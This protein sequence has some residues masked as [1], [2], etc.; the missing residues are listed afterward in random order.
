MLDIKVSIENKEVVIQGLDKLGFGIDIA[1]TKGLQ[2]A[3]V[4][5]FGIAFQW[6]SGAGGQT[7]TYSREWS[8][9]GEIRR[10][11]K[12]GAAPGG[13]P[14]PVRTGNLRRLLNWLW[15]G[16]SKSG[17]AG[18]FTAGPDEFVIYDSASYAAA[19]F[20]GRGSSAPYGPR[21]ALRDALELFNHGGM[22]QQLIG[23]EITKEMNKHDS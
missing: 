4:G 17:D 2:R 10:K 16:E 7:R 23:E 20:L 5:I 15:P 19:V 3:T 6:L 8:A 14:V 13:Y 1:A 22:I 18:T 12:Y 21:D 9:G 11:K